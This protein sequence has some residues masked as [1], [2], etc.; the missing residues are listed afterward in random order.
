MEHSQANFKAGYH[1]Q[2]REPG[3]SF[4]EMFQKTLGIRI[5]R[6]ARGSR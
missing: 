1:Q 3:T 6:E 4:E 2:E 5:G